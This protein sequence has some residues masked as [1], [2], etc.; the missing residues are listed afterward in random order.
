VVELVFVFQN[1][2][3]VVMYSNSRFYSHNSLQRGFLPG[4]ILDRRG[5]SPL[6]WAA[7]G[8]YIEMVRYLVEEC[9]CDPSQGQKG[10]RS[11]SGRTALHWA[12]RNGH[13]RV[14]EYLV[15]CSRVDLEAATIDGTAAFGWACWQGHL[16]IME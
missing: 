6:M 14:V 4:N 5:A 8:G 15:N 2:C 10:K 1:A 9:G 7:G 11:F 12:A 13:F 3:P 16:P